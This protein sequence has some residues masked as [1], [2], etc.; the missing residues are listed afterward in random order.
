MNKLE[1][2]CDALTTKVKNMSDDRRMGINR[3]CI[4]RGEDGYEEKIRR[5][6]T[7]IVQGIYLVDWC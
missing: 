5:S 2:E 7:Y 6:A 4:V 1:D 3:S